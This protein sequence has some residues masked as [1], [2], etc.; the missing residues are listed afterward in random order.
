MKFN[1]YLKSCRKNHNLTQEELIQELYNF[2]ESFIG[3]DT[4]TLIRWEQAQTKPSI[5]RQIIIIRY[6]QTINK[7]ILPC[8]DAIDKIDIENKIC[9]IGVKNLIGSSKEHI[10][11]FPT[12]SF[13]VHNIVISH[14]RSAKDIDN[15]LKMP[16]DV[17]KNLTGNVYNLS[18]ETI[19]EWALHPSNLFLLSE[20]KDQFAGILFTLR[21]KPIVFERIINFDID[22]KD[23]YLNDFANFNE[24]GCNFPMAFFAY[25]DKSSTLLILRYYAHLI[26]NQDV[27]QQIGATPLLE[28]AKKIVEK[29][30]MH[31]HKEKEV[32][33]GILTSYQAP[34]CDVLINETVIKMIFQK[35]ECS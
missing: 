21:L 19:K 25:N 1:E 33:Q 28:G 9:K 7:H 17:I 12:K 20:Y 2:D 27:I 32:K 22:L 10:L 23:I 11:N 29:M 3:V 15:V 16:Y 8:F 34:L 18:F 4:R 13:E 14:I 24:A 30:N 35:Q 6:F 31:Y 5:N 26:A